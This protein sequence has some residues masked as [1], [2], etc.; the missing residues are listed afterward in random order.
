[1]DLLHQALIGWTQPLDFCTVRR[2]KR[3]GFAHPTAAFVTGTIKPGISQQRF[4]AQPGLRV[5]I[6]IPGSGPDLG[7]I[8][9]RRATEPLTESGCDSSLPAAQQFIQHWQRTPGTGVINATSRHL[10][11]TQ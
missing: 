3:L 11:D 4:Q 2:L 5:Q 8:S 1:M 6:S 7:N 9:Q 10:V